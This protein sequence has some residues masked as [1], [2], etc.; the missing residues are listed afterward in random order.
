MTTTTTTCFI[1]RILKADEG[2]LL[3]SRAPLCKLE[4]TAKVEVSRVM[5]GVVKSVGYNCGPAQCETRP[6]VS[7]LSYPLL[8]VS[9]RDIEYQG[10][11]EMLRGN[12]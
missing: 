7:F 1:D 10:G 9:K 3:K 12:G 2:G 8:A 11:K 6:P 5:R 4:Y